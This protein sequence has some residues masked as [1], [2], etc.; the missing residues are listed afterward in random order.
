MLVRLTEHNDSLPLDPSALTRFHSRATPNISLSAYLRRIAKYTSIEKCC[1]LILLV[2]IDRVCERLEG[3]TICGLTVHRFICAAILCASKALCDA[4][5]TNEHYAKVGGISLQEINLLEKEFLQIIDWR[6]ICGGAELQHYYASLVRNHKD[7]VL[8]EPKRAGQNLQEQKQ[9]HGLAAMELDGAEASAGSDMNGHDGTSGNTA[10]DGSIQAGATAQ[11]ASSQHSS[12][13]PLPIGS[14]NSNSNT[15]TSASPFTTSTATNGS[16]RSLTG[17]ATSSAS[18]SSSGDSQRGAAAGSSSSIVTSPTS[19]MQVDAEPW[20]TS[21]VAAPAMMNRRRK[22]EHRTP[23]SPL[24]Q[25]QVHAP[26][27]GGS[28]VNAVQTNGHASSTQQA[29]HSTVSANADAY[30]RTRF[31]HP[32]RQ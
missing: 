30:K 8:D 29:Q 18:G 9:E 25:S 17:V 15:S 1:V 28:S 7:Y 12:P 3:F 24:G 22:D 20:V 21:Q 5:N 14:S 16:G 10:T 11:A 19:A 26:Q 13:F 31:D 27:N 6:L 4:F 2:Y 23:P 32:P